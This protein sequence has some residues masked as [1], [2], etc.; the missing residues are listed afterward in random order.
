MD[1]KLLIMNLLEKMDNEQL[2]KLYWFIIGIMD[3]KDANSMV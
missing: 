3:N 2:E 1:Y